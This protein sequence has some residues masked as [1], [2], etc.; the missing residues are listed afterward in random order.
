MRHVPVNLDDGQQLGVQVA[1]ACAVRMSISRRA[2]E[3]GRRPRRGSE[4]ASPLDDS[5]D[6]STSLHPHFSVL[7]LSHRLLLERRDYRSARKRFNGIV[8]IA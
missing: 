6:D 2:A 5:P 7:A 3:A 4:A 8:I 1:A